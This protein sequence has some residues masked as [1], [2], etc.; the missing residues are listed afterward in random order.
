[1]STQ[2]PLGYVNNLVLGLILTYND[3]TKLQTRVSETNYFVLTDPEIF[4]DPHTFD[5]DRW[6]RAAAKGQHLDKYMVNFSK[7]SRICL[8]MKYVI[9]HPL[10]LKTPIDIYF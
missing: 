3:L 2:Y 1:M 9:R 5:P 8:G 10:S 4:P 6:L 7:G